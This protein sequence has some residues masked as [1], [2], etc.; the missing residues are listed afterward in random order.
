[1][2]F[3]IYELLGL[4]NGILPVTMSKFPKLIRLKARMA[5]VPQIASY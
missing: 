5:K 4:V 1:M 2:D 3:L